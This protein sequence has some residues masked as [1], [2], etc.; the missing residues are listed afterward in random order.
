MADDKAAEGGKSGGLLAKVLGAVFGAIIAPILVA[1]GIKYLSPAEHPPDSKPAAEVKEKAV[2]PPTS[3]PEA[4]KPRT[5]GDLIT[6]HL[7]ENFYSFGWSPDAGKPVKNDQVDPR[8]FQFLEDPPGLPR[9]PS[10]HV[11]GDEKVGY[12]STKNEFENYTLYVWWKWG[13]KTFGPRAD[14][15]RFASVLV[16]IGGPDGQLKGVL[17][18][19]VVVHLHEGQIGNIRLMG[20]EDVI[21]C[22]ARVK[23]GP[24]Q[25]DRPVYDKGATPVAL[26]S[27]GNKIKE[28]SSKGWDGTIY[29]LGFDEGKFDDTLEEPG[30]PSGGWNRLR[31]DCEGGTVT[32]H[33]G[34]K[35]VNE[36]TGCNQTRGRIGFVSQQA[37]WYI[38]KVEVVPKPK[39]SGAG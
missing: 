7:G 1:V 10:I 18:Q 25:D 36:I 24:G 14:K 13:E 2:V 33:V 38:G 9:G 32:V 23:Q 37:E 34:G 15:K 12:L 19:A 17:P 29:R 27:T 16:H 20:P 21:K 11:P 28:L 6:P 3:A 30:K 39:P 5:E 26:A 4:V 35:V 22:Q 31:V 8:W